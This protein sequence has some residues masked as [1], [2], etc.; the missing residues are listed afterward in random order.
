MVIRDAADKNIKSQEQEN[1]KR[2]TGQKKTLTAKYLKPFFLRAYKAAVLIKTIRPGIGKSFKFGSANVKF[3]LNGKNINFPPFRMTER[4]IELA[5]ADMFISQYRYE[6]LIEVGAVS[7]YY[8]P[9]RIKTIVD[10]YD[11]HPLVTHR[12][13]WITHQGKYNAI[14]S[15][16]TFEH[17]GLSDY[18]LVGDL[19]KSD[20][21]LSKLISS[22]SD[23]LVTW[24]AGYNNYLDQSVLK[25]IPT[26]P[27]VNLFVWERGTTGNK[28]EEIH[29]INKRKNKFTYGPYWANTLFVLYRGPG[30]LSSSKD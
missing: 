23:F 24:P 21:A 9:R 14:L 3:Y 26:W 11:T 17:I 6:D 4:S 7:P 22:A 18:G 19:E 29:D 8:W 12:E 25:K 5:L 1:M 30:L 20:I 10:P 13:D 27:K 15:I 16:S 28:W 2:G